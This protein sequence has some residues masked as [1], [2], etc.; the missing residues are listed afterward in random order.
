MVVCL[1]HVG[2]LGS[3]QLVPQIQKE[4]VVDNG[5]DVLGK[6]YKGRKLIR[7]SFT[8]M[9]CFVD[10]DCLYKEFMFSCLEYELRRREF[11]DTII[12]CLE[13][14]ISVQCPLGLATSFRRHD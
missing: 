2:V 9:L 8:L 1:I 11:Q 3:L 10:I 13:N 12:F 7:F 5:V 4:L 6:L 14:E